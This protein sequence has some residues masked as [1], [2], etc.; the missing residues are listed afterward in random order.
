[1]KGFGLALAIGDVN[2]DGYP[3]IYV[4]NDFISND[5]LYINQGNGTFKE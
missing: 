5:I 3:I 1:M 2:K 4:S